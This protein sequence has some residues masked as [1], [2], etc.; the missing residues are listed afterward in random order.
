MC[1]AEVAKRGANLLGLALRGYA[2]EPENL[3]GTF[4]AGRNSGRVRLL[5]NQVAERLLIAPK[6]LFDDRH[7]Y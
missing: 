5:R 3:E 4:T 2:K 1:P 7:V 6:E